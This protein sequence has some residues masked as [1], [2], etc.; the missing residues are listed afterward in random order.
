MM[1]MMRMRM[2][3]RV[4]CNDSPDLRRAGVGLASVRRS[5]CALPRCWSRVRQ[6]AWRLLNPEGDSHLLDRIS[7][8]CCCCCCCCGLIQRRTYT[9]CYPCLGGCCGQKIRVPVNCWYP[10]WPCHHRWRKEAWNHSFPT[11]PKRNSGRS[12]TLVAWSPWRGWTGIGATMNGI[13]FWPSSEIGGYQ[14]VCDRLSTFERPLPAPIGCSR[15]CRC[16]RE[17]TGDCAPW[18]TLQRCRGGEDSPR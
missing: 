14:E 5:G 11:L 12:R 18:K 13:R 7:R 2:R 3:K 1:M 15:P 9:R 8:C 10:R 6:V 16:G 4:G 17:S